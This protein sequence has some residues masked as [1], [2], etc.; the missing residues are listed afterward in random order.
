GEVKVYCLFYLCI[1][2][3]EATL[4]LWLDSSGGKVKG[5]TF[6]ASSLLDSHYL[7]TGMPSTP[8]TCSSHH[9]GVRH[10][11]NKWKSRLLNMQGL[12]DIYSKVT[13]NDKNGT[14]EMYGLGVRASYVWVWL[15]RC[16]N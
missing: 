13:G 12:Q 7:V 2:E 8:S 1:S 3:H 11:R 15:Q 4:D 6:S 10:L 16:L 14:T 9:E 5:R